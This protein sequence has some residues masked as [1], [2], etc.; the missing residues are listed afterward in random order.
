MG[1]LIMQV[2]FSFCQHDI[3]EKKKN[4]EREGGAK[5]EKG[6]GRETGRREG[7]CLSL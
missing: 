4:K 7:A 2:N 6:K 5:K 3:F 1:E